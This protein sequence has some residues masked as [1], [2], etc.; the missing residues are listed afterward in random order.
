MRSGYDAFSAPGRFLR[1]NVHTHSDRSDGKGTPHEVCARYEGLGYDFLCLS[2]HFLARYGFPI[3]DTRQY[4]SA[5]FT[6]LLGAEV[7]AGANSQD[8]VWHILAVGLPADFAPTADGESG[9]AL[10]ARAKAAGAFVGIA[11]PQWSALTI[12][13]GRAMA[14]HAHAVE[15]YNTTCAL[16]TGRPDGTALWDRLLCEGYDHLGGYAADDAHFKI[17]DTGYAWMMVKA[18]ENDPDALLEAMKAGHYY[19]STGPSLEALHEDGDAIEVVS[20]PVLTLT[21]VGRGTRCVTVSGDDL[22]RARLPLAPF[23]GDWCRVMAIERGGGIAWSN[24]IFVA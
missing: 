15:V 17:H 11:H 14:P 8:E 5:R 10:A 20:S 1:G 18:R 4:R 19:A 24:P 22:T 12:E 9:E 21:A 7:H 3:T 2:D 13:D 6:T 16:E 23:R